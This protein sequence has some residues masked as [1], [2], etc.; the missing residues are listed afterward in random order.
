MFNGGGVTTGFSKTFF[1]GIFFTGIT[2]KL[3]SL[4]S[5]DPI[6]I[7]LKVTSYC[8]EALYLAGSTLFAP[9]LDL[10]L[11]IVRGRLLGKSFV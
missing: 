6:V 7:L 2:Y 9:Y 3:V 4:T 11:F 8:L 5:I 1:S 10:P